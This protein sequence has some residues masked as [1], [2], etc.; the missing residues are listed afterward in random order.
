MKAQATSPAGTATS[1]CACCEEPSSTF[2]ASAQ[3][4][5]T[6]V[7]PDSRLVSQDTRG[8]DIKNKLVDYALVV[9]HSLI[10]LDK[11]R[12]RRSLQSGSI[13]SCINHTPSSYARLLTKPIAVSIETK[14]ND[15]NESEGTVQLALWVATHFN[16]LRALHSG[17][18]GRR[19]QV[20]MPLPLIAVLG[21]QYRLYFAVDD[22]DEI[23]ILGG[24]CFG[25]TESLLG[26]YQVLGV[27]KGVCEW[28]RDIYVP[29]FVKMCL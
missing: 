21:S 13:L 19:R 7:R 18:L 11:V 15:A 1:M 16:R 26:C 6:A 24:K 10:P 17:E 28:I 8:G 23:R 20:S 22:E 4:N 14:T 27:L 29:W 3:E 25:D 2:R 12:A 5:V 9:D